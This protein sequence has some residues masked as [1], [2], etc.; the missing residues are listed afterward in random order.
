[1]IQLSETLAVSEMKEGRSPR[2]L[3]AR[4]TGGLVVSSTHAVSW[5]VIKHQNKSVVHNIEKHT[6]T[7]G[8][9]Y[10]WK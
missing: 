9:L 1:M 10:G 6:G 8:Q 2:G 4:L 5:T 3:P 7:T